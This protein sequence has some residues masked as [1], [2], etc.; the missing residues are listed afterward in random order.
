[1]KTHARRAAGTVVLSI[2]LIILALA[3]LVGAH[4]IYYSLATYQVSGAPGRLVATVNISKVV[5]PITITN[6]TSQATPDPFQLQLNFSPAAYSAFEAPDLSNVRF[7]YQGQ[8]L[9]A[10]LQSYSSSPPNRAQLATAWVKLPFSIGPHQSVTIYMAFNGSGWDQY[11]GEAPTLS[12][13]Y[14]AHDNGPYVFL[15]YGA[16]GS[17]FDGWT[18]G[19]FT[20]GFAPTPAGGGIM[21]VNNQGGEGTYLVAPNPLPQEPL[22]VDV[23]W[24][25][26]APGG[27]TPADALAISIGNAASQIPVTSVGGTD[28]GGTPAASGSIFAQNEFYPG[29]PVLA[30]KDAVADDIVGTIPWQTWQVELAY[31]AF[32][33]IPPNGNGGSWGSMAGYTII[34]NSLPS[35]P[36]SVQPP[37]YVNMLDAGTSYN[38][39]PIP[40]D[41]SAPQG[42]DLELGAGSGGATAYTYVYWALARA[43]PPDDVMPTAVAGAPMVP[44][45]V[46]N[47]GP[48][49]VHITQVVVVSNGAPTYYP[50]S[51]ALFPGQSVTVYI[52]LSG[53]VGF[54]TNNGIVWARAVR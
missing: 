7:Y 38:G 41:V 45:N 39:A 51:A 46:T 40:F 12:T 23:E 33:L 29:W 47:Y 22:V 18:P 54:E 5:V 20:G 44:V 30:L 28:G 21:M 17:G 36:P 10:W 4:M 1:M 3:I 26:S 52:P 15:A 53:S 2:A 19:V 27:E 31:S 24:G 11:W 42:M 34:P 35:S 16:F 49:E 43:Y 9:Y 50:Y 6:P 8:E 37:Q 13:P 32:N 25:F 48:V 14:G